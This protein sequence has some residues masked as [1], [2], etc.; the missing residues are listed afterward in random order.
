LRQTGVKIYFED[1]GLLKV[2]SSDEA[3]AAMP[4]QIIATLHDA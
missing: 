1:S 2:A 3:S 4:L